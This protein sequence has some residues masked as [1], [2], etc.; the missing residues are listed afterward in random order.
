VTVDEAKAMIARVDASD[1]AGI[2]WTG[3]QL[4]DHGY[5]LTEGGIWELSIPMEIAT[6]L[7][8]EA[9]GG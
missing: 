8:T 1:A 7:T 2:E 9:D 3:E 5:I 4:K 6:W